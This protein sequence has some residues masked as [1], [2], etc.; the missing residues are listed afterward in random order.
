[1][2]I[3]EDY[4]S[5]E[6]AK[7]L[8]EKGFDKFIV[9]GWDEQIFDK[10]NPRYFSLNFDKKEHWISCPTHQTAMKWL[11]TEKNIYIEIRRSFD[12]FLYGAIILKQDGIGIA[13][14]GK[15]YYYYEEAVEA[16]LKYAL[17]NLI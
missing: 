5:Y 12:T 17:E 2:N 9:Y 14:I 1:M 4:C 8:K 3:T 15:T 11:R 16:S 6:V 7:L 13:E 10:E